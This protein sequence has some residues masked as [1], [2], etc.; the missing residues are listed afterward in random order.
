MGKGHLFSFQ[1]K[2]GIFSSNECR[3]SERISLGLASHCDAY[4]IIHVVMSTF[5]SSCSHIGIKETLN[6][7]PNAHAGGQ[8]RIFSEFKPMDSIECIYLK[9]NIF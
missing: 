7:E 1:S 5:D 4:R 8:E 9:I 3:D 6:K 2:L